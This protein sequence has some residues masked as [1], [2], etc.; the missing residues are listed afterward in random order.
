MTLNIIFKITLRT[1]VDDCYLDRWKQCETI[2]MTPPCTCVDNQF[3]INGKIQPQLLE[4]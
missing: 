2:R 4:P 3:L 1:R